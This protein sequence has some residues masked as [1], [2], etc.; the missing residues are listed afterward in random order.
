VKDLK[1]WHN[2]STVEFPD[3]DEGVAFLLS[4]LKYNQFLSAA[5]RG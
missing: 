1:E 3:F 2:E 5:R 4:Y